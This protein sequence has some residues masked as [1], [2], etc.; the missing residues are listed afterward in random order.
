MRCFKVMREAREFIH[1]EASESGV[2]TG[3]KHSLFV[4]RMENLA[5]RVFGREA[6]GE[7]KEACQA[8]VALIKELANG[9]RKD[10][11][12]V[13]W[14]DLTPEQRKKIVAYGLRAVL[15][16][17]SAD[18]MLPETAEA[19]HNYD[20]PSELSIESPGEND[21]IEFHIG[22]E[23]ESRDEAE[24][25]ALASTSWQTDYWQLMIYESFAK[26][27]KGFQESAGRYLNTHSNLHYKSGRALDPDR[28]YYYIPVNEIA[29][30]ID[31]S[32][33]DETGTRLDDKYI[34][35]KERLEERLSADGNYYIFPKDIDSFAS[36]REALDAFSALK[37]H[38]ELELIRGEIKDFIFV[39]PEKAADYGISREEMREAIFT[40]LDL[41]NDVNLDMDEIDFKV[42]ETDK[43]RFLINTERRSQIERDFI[44]ELQNQT[45]NYSD[46]QK[47][48]VLSVLGDMFRFN[49][50]Q[51]LREQGVS[52]SGRAG[53]NAIPLSEFVLAAKARESFGWTIPT[54]VC[55]QINQKLPEIAQRALGLSGLTQTTYAGE[56]HVVG[57]V[58]LQNGEIAVLDYGDMVK[59]GTPDLKKAAS[60]YERYQG[61]VQGESLVGDAAGNIRASIKSQATQSREEAM[62]FK[63]GEE[64]LPELLLGG[65][66]IETKDGLVV[67]VENEKQELAINHN[68]LVASFIKL[69]KSADPYNALAELYGVRIG[70]QI[71][72]KYSFHTSSTFLAEKLKGI[73][74]DQFSKNMELGQE[75]G[76]DYL[77]KFSL[78]DNT[79][80]A[81]ANTLD[82][83]IVV[84]L[85]NKNIASFGAG[86]SF[87]IKFSYIDPDRPLEFHMS[88]AEHLQGSI[89]N[90]QTSGFGE[91]GARLHHKLAEID[92]AAKM[93]VS[94]KVGIA[95]SVGGGSG[96]VF[97]QLEAEGG[98]EIG[99]FSAAASFSK[100]TS[101]DLL[102]LPHSESGELRISS[103]QE[104][105]GR[106]SVITVYGSRASQDFGQ[107]ELG[108]YRFK[109][110]LTVL[111]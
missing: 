97:K 57:A 41:V 51:A 56:M 3:Q 46:G 39:S 77:Q 66:T 18:L 101:K 2:A 9:L 21:D 110:G 12:L 17:I 11:A 106:E 68:H 75:F 31:E 58:R 61:V 36:G 67:T 1:T 10:G 30:F 93:T 47:L 63:T 99:K 85:D 81:L 29:R 111:F 53:G 32:R 100:Q 59:T 82:G 33:L 54:G 105:A 23:A 107:Q 35:L 13:K 83:F 65:R 87:G 76:F 4:E 104:L 50:D 80:V 90:I 94:E 92:V 88:A 69:D 108:R 60:F 6:V 70:T 91:G 26:E 95:I 24:T 45:K 25:V 38:P 109:A 20:S 14:Q 74:L 40:I 22:Y 49:Y 103:K 8:Q 78:N 19:G 5:E 28:D 37:A 55:R 86:D 27:V 98:V 72:E 52:G 42:K 16:V 44:N 64:R 62:H 79:Y 43:A 34:F 7:V 71:G 73:N 48:A 102:F 89:G 15:G 84:N 96:D